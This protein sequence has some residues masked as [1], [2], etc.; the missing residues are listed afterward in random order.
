MQKVGSGET[1]VGSEEPQRHS[2][3]LST[4][5]SLTEKYW[6]FFDYLGGDAKITSQKPGFWSARDR[7][8]IRCQLR[9]RVSLNISV[10]IRKSP[11]QKPGF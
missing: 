4:P 10:G 9:N 5:H 3:L 2:P 1:E 11:S 8:A 7:G 6:G